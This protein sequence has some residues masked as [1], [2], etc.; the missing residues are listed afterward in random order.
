MNFRVLDRFSNMLVGVV[1]QRGFLF[2]WFSSHS[3]CNLEGPLGKRRFRL[4]A[5]CATHGEPCH[6][7]KDRMTFLQME[8]TLAVLADDHR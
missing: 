8:T 4:L 1:C 2:V 7:T 3:H 5:D 6:A